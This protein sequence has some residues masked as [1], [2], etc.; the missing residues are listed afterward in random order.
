MNPFTQQVLSPCLNYHGPCYFPTE[1]LD[2]KGRLRKRYRHEDL[3]TPYDKLNSLPRA[4]RYPKEGITSNS[5]MLSLTPS[6][7]MTPPSASMRPA[8]RYSGPSTTT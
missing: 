8:T 3:M 7:I 1:A 4:E 2:A 6:A 5:S